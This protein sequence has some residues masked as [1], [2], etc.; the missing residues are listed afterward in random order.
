MFYRTI[1]TKP[2][3]LAGDGVAVPVV[4]FLATHIFELILASALAGQKAA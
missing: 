1:T 3:T 4:S 2:I